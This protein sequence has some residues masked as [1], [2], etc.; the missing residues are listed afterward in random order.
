MNNETPS[1]LIAAAPD[2]LKALVLMEKAQAH[3]EG[4]P[5]FPTTHATEAARFKLFDARQAARAAIAK[6]TGIP[7]P[8]ATP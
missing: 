3:I 2:L 1:S 6:A 7:A 4:L 8:G 5:M